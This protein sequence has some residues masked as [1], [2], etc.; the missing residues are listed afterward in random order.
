[1][2]LHWPFLFCF[3]ESLTGAQTERSSFLWQ[4]EPENA[5]TTNRKTIANL[6]YAMLVDM[7]FSLEYQK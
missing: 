6:K 1:M 2:K 4:S 3:E 7:A 5:T